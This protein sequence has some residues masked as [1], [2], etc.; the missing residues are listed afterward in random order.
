MPQPR[1]NP[2][3][4]AAW[5]L[6]H[7]TGRKS[8]PP[9][10]LHA[11]GNLD[12]DVL[13]LTEFVDG[14][15]QVHFKDSLKDL[16]FESVAVSVKAPRQNQVLMA[17]RTKMADDDLLPIPGYTEAAATNWLHRRIPALGI[18]VVGLRAPMYLSADERTGYWQQV[19]GIAQLGQGRPLLLLGDFNCDPHTDT[20]PCTEALRRLQQ[21]EGFHLPNPIGDWSCRTEDG[22]S[23][24]RIDHALASPALRVLE[25]RFLYKAG[26]TLL[27][28]P[29]NGDVN[30]HSGPLSDHALLS[31]K[32]E[33]PSA[34][35]RT[36]PSNHSQERWRADNKPA[37]DAY[38]AQVDALGTFAGAL[39]K[40]R[41]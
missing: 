27:A 24:T 3:H 10:V 17:A 11:I 4:L 38:D 34:G 9:A 40:F 19:A 26:R 13:V 36:S 39:R 15:H 2:L 32:L 16:G 30:D 7:R 29:A 31:I 8:I 6:N 25:A 33:R 23:T 35:M 21:R 18:E 1:P 5:N 28:G 20:R 12:L 22:R 41:P 14:D 37:I